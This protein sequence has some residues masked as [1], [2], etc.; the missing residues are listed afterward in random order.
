[1]FQALHALYFQL[2]IVKRIIALAAE[3]CLRRTSN[4]TQNCLEKITR[5][6][7]EGMW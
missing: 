7:I 5:R 4:L 6:I 3:I 2:Q 1:M